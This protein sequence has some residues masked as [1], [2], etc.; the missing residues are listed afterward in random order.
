MSPQGLALLQCGE[1][2]A[3]TKTPQSI[4]QQISVAA[5]QSSVISVL[6][7][8]PGEICALLAWWFHRRALA[9]LQAICCHQSSHLE[10]GNNNHT[11]FL[12]DLS[13]QFPRV[14]REH[15]VPWTWTPPTER[16]AAKD[17]ARVMNRISG[18]RGRADLPFEDGT[19]SAAFKL[20]YKEK[21]N[22]QS[23]K[24][25]TTTWSR[26]GNMKQI[27]SNKQTTEGQTEMEARITTVWF[28]ALA[29]RKWMHMDRVWR[30]TLIKTES[31]SNSYRR[32]P[33]D[34]Y[35]L[36]DTEFS[37]DWFQLKE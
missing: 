12:P 33:L 34:D 14:P 37:L 21:Q 20:R 1:E 7:P 6:P 4:S 3:L 11:H 31:L 5:S 27:C 10:L 9:R 32:P 29:V 16:L 23:S 19:R 24:K 8:V 2:P 18:F 22:T 17:A 28:D 26:D 30:A 36:F 15:R 13:L 35:I 25:P